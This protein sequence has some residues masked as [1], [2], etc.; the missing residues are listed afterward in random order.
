MQS[1][2]IPSAV[3][4]ADIRSATISFNNTVTNRFLIAAI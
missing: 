2:K 3:G 1:E 4:A